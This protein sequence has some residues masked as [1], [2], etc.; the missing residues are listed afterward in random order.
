MIGLSDAQL[1]RRKINDINRDNLNS[2]IMELKAGLYI[3][4]TPIGN[5]DD[6]TLRALFLLKNCDIIYCEDTRVTQ[7]LLQKHSITAK[8]LSVYND[9][10]DDYIRGRIVEDVANGKAI[11]LVSDAGT[12]LIADPGY[13]IVRE[14]HENDL[15]VDVIPGPCAAISA[16]ILSG[17]PT[18]K[19]F[20]A[21]FMPKTSVSR[22]KL[23]SSL[24]DLE[25]TLIFYEAPS[26]ILDSLKQIQIS[27]G[28]REVAVV[29]E[30]TKIFQTVIRKKVSELI[31]SFDEVNIRGEF[32]VL[33]SPKHPDEKVDVEKVKLTIQE[34]K[35][36]NKTTK[37]IAE[38]LVKKY[39]KK[40]TKNDIY[41]M[42]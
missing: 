12:P 22:D 38:I 3:V 1:A 11:V 19:F 24:E 36:N 17:M 33:V 5:L 37:D 28:D 42:C 4:S 21:G 31:N 6:I 30:I 8:K 7:R 34:M 29:K 40:L 18:D 39:N 32:V 26:R 14:L 41:K 23:L 2:L 16:L 10:S 20:F 35:K 13:K 9:H 27:L 25:A 15:L